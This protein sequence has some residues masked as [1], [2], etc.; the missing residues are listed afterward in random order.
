MTIEFWVRV[1]FGLLQ[2]IKKIKKKK[3]LTQTSTVD[4][5]HFSTLLLPGCF[6][7]TFATKKKKKGVIML[8]ISKPTH[9]PFE[10]KRICID[11]S[12]DVKESTSRMSIK[13]SLMHKLDFLWENNLELGVMLIFLIPYADGVRS[14]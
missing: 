1:G 4:I 11:K 14:F 12:N 2:Y 10:N 7:R 6:F 8:K 13:I 9:I 3:R 5:A